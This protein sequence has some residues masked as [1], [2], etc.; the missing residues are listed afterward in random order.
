MNRRPGKPA[1]PKPF[2]ITEQGTH[3]TTQYQGSN[4]LTNNIC[5][6][7][8]T[9][10][11]MDLTGYYEALLKG[12]GTF[13]YFGLHDFNDD[14]GLFDTN[15]NPRPR[16]TAFR[17]HYILHED[18]GAAAKTFTPSPAT[19]TASPA[20]S[21]GS[22]DANVAVANVFQKSNGRTLIQVW[23]RVAIWNGTAAVT[24]T[25][26]TVTLT[27]GAAHKAIWVFD[28]VNGKDPRPARL[29]RQHDHA[30]ADGPSADRGRVADLMVSLR[31]LGARVAKL[32]TGGA[33][34]I[35]PETFGAV[36]DGA[37]HPASSKYATLAALQ[38]VFP[39]A[40]D[41]SQEL[42]WLGWQAALNHGGAIACTGLETYKMCNA[43]VG[44]NVA[45]TVVAGRSWGDAHGATM[46]WGQLQPQTSANV[47]VTDPTFQTTTAWQNSTGTYTPDKISNVTFGGGRGLIRRPGRGAADGAVRRPLLRLRSARQPRAGPL[48]RDRDLLGIGGCKLRERELQPALRDAGLPVRGPGGRL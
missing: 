40:S 6:D 23:P 5:T 22:Y 9:T 33:G 19:F 29:Q 10:A 25:T 48:P 4:S 18:K 17:N 24:P 21:T 11:K 31:D 32:E 7:G 34:A 36:G 27:F 13:C 38:A 16:A 46:D 1:T 26:Q 14:Y 42:D 37:S 8:P 15:L 41:L 12:V 28:P 20:F 45:L 30:D 47:Y 3:A 43:A 39:F 44:S 2:A 35:S